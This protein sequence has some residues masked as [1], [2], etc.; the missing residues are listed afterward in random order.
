MSRKQAAHLTKAREGKKRIKV[1]EQEEVATHAG[2]SDSNTQSHVMQVIEENVGNNQEDDNDDDSIVDL[3]SI[4]TSGTLTDND[5]DIGK[6][7]IDDDDDNETLE[8][9][10]R[11]DSNIQLYSFNSIEKL[12]QYKFNNRK[13]DYIL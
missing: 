4:A 10:S 2:D 1:N 5:S 11:D 7:N 9:D 12:K 6:I 3:S 8:G 13:K